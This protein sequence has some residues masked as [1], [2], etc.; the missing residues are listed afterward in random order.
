MSLS[1]LLDVYSIKLMAGFI[2]IC[3]GN[4]FFYI[5][6]NFMKMFSSM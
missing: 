2:H 1:G 3:I 4:F 5:H 6:I